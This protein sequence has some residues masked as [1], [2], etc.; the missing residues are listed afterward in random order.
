MPDN[1]IILGKSA[2]DW[3]RDLN[4]T[5]RS[6]L[7]IAAIL[8]VLFL[9]IAGR[10]FYTVGS[11]EQGVVL[12]FGK[13]VRTTPPGLHPKFPWPIETVLTPDVQRIRRIT[14]G[15]RGVEEG[16]YPGQSTWNRRDE[17]D[18]MNESL[19]LTGDLNI[20][21]VQLSI[22]YRIKDPV[23][24][25]FNANEPEEAL[26]S[27]CESTLRRVVGD[28]GVDAPLTGGKAAIEDEIQIEAQELADH[29]GL[30]LSIT[31]ANLQD[32]QAPPE[33]QPA[34]KGVVT[35]KENKQKYINESLGYQ[36]GEIPRAEGMA[37]GVINQASAYARERVLK[38][39]GEVSRF[40]A[41]LAEYRKAPE[42]T[43]NRLYLETLEEVLGKVEATVIDK[44]TPSLLPLLHLNNPESLGISNPV[45]ESLETNPNDAPY[46]GGQP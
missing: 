38:A 11:M 40:S 4:R 3:R 22:Q 35:A 39:Q 37:A 19:M 33:V 24:Y 10:P 8:L 28:Y 30:G 15:F 32:V 25:L 26:K 41:L 36:N 5:L 21:M 13:H 29:Y 1:V 14:I 17:S 43:Q 34:F 44:N 20:L 2:E 42:V 6:G 16:A 23:A 46:R 45:E 31:L 9:A 7:G 18:G 27:L 12:R